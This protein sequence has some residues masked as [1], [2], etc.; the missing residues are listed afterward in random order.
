VGDWCA[1]F[2]VPV[3]RHL[4]QSAAVLRTITLLAGVASPPEELS[5]Q[6]LV[7]KKNRVTRLFSRQTQIRIGQVHASRSS[8]YVN[9]FAFCGAIECVERHR[10]HTWLPARAF[11]WFSS[12]WMGRSHHFMLS[13]AKKVSVWVEDVITIAR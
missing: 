2:R 9:S 4:L 6:S 5:L 7:R 8:G 10:E 13:V 11:L 12:E 1:A 3:L